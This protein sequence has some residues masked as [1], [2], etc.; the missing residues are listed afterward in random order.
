[1]FFGSPRSLVSKSARKLPFEVLA[2]WQSAQCFFTNEIGSSR[3]LDGSTACKLA[4]G[5]SSRAAKGTRVKFSLIMVLCVPA[6]IHV[7]LNPVS[8]ILCNLRRGLTIILPSKRHV[9][10]YYYRYALSEDLSY[11]FTMNIGQAV[12]A[13]NMAPSQLG[14]V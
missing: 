1:M 5:T 2:S 9:S 7:Y 8:R 14:M 6:F 3:L 4:S 10:L 13:A 12:I 11:H